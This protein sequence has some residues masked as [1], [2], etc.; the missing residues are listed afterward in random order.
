[1]LRNKKHIIIN[2]EALLNTDDINK[3][4]DGRITAYG[5]KHINNY[6]LFSLRNNFLNINKESKELNEEYLE[7]LKEHF[8]IPLT[9]K[10]LIRFKNV[11]LE[12]YSDDI[13]FKQGALEL[14]KYLNEEGYNII[15]YANYDNWKTVIDSKTVL[16]DFYMNKLL[17]V[18]KKI[19]KIKY[20]FL[21]KFNKNY[22]DSEVVNTVL[23]EC[24]AIESSLQGVKAAVN[25]V[26]VICVSDK[27]AYV[28]FDFIN[29]LA[30]YHFSDFTQ[31][32]TSLNKNNAKL[33]QSLQ[34][35]IL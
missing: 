15:L 5:S 33:I 32:L 7:Y 19:F 27:S 29:S 22:C 17:D 1:M 10:Q 12:E 18:F 21:N 34:E 9:L 30:D 16:N 14:L 2:F 20:G 3:E 4:I 35:E 31:L 8:N 13:E 23:N 6:N 11:L 26:E 24:I 25:S 28:D